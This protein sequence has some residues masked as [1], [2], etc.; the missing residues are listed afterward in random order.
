[1]KT[2]I[3]KTRRGFT[4]VELLVVIVIIAALAGLAVPQLIKMRKK[5]DVAEAVNNAKQLGL[6]LT[7]FEGDYGSYPDDTTAKRVAGTEFA[8]ADLKGTDS[9]V[10]FKQLFAAGT[11]D[12]E[13][14][15]FAKTSYSK[16]KPDDVFNTK[17]EALK[18][19][20]CGFGYIMKDANTA[21]SMSGSRPIALTPCAAADAT[22][23]MELEPYDGK[24]VVLFVDNSARS[25][26]IS[27]DTDQTAKFTSGKTLIEI[28]D[29]TVWGADITTA[30]VIQPPL[31][32]A[33]TP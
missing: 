14:P 5:A 33:P 26:N 25:L 10:Y 22:G 15:F 2:N 13:Q 27:R 19:G 16:T 31:S 17:A 4:L 6:A 9:N 7:M 29:D 21:I 30:P 18:A 28:G 3:Q 8:E 24:A 20:E 1:M 11:V 12:S 23:K 32:T